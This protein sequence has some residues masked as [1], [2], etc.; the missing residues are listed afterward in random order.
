MKAIEARSSGL[1]V[2]VVILGVYLVRRCCPSL[3]ANLT[4]ADVESGR[5]LRSPSALLSFR[6]MPKTLFQRRAR[7]GVI[8]FA[9]FVFLW[10]AVPYHPR[11]HI[12]TYQQPPSAWSWLNP[13]QW[14]FVPGAARR[15]RIQKTY[16]RYAL[17]PDDPSPQQLP[18]PHAILPDVKITRLP[19]P[20]SHQRFPQAELR[21]LYPAGPP[22][23]E[24]EYNEHVV[25]PRVPVHEFIKNWTSPEW[26]DHQGRNARQLP[27][28]QH[29]FSQESVS[30]E[31]RK[32]NEDRA[33]AVKRA[34]VYAWQQYKDHAWGES[35]YACVYMS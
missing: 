1:P 13:L 9:C 14:R 3:S 33:E 22:D 17:A 18:P 7:L 25:A 27:T 32:L 19:Y 12:A 11:R 35:C 8:V 4:M 23:L 24:E 34:F 30:E 6:H 21:D 16:D 28:V 29:D 15:Q 5:G 10:W 26:F 31:R 2:P 20:S